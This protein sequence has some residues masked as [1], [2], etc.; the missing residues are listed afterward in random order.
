MET[1]QTKIVMSCPSS[2]LAHFVATMR[3]GRGDEQ[4]TVDGLS[5]P[6]TLFPLWNH[7]PSRVPFHFKFSPLTT[8]L[9]QKNPNPSQGLPPRR[10]RIQTLE[11]ELRRL[12]R[13]ENCV[14]EV[15]LAAEGKMR[16]WLRR[17]RWWFTWI[18]GGPFHVAPPRRHASW[19]W[20]SSVHSH[21]RWVLLTV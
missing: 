20:R 7:V 12:V 5:R 1:K 19:R 3:D 21:N 15:C 14:R 6:I 16:P 4:R 8:N 2:P 18:W 9:Y 17:R 13:A 11:I 10:H